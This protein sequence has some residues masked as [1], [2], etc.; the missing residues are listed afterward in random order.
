MLV[1]KYH[2]KNL[3]QALA[4]VKQDLGDHATVL[5]TRTMRRG[6]LG[7]RRVEVTAALSPT[8]GSL[9]TLPSRDESRAGEPSRPGAASYSTPSRPPAAKRP[10][11]PDTAGLAGRELERLV[12]PLREEIRALRREVS[13]DA[14]T[15]RS[16][17]QLRTQVG[18]LQEQMR[19][20][21]DMVRIM[22]KQEQERE[23]VSVTNLAQPDD[24]TAMAWQ[25]DSA[26]ESLVH[27]LAESGMSSAG[28]QHVIGDVRRVLPAAPEEGRAC[29]T[30]LAAQAIESRIQCAAGILAKGRPVALVGPPGV[31][32]TTTLAKI[33]TRAALIEGLNVGVIG[34]DTDTL[35]ASDALELLAQTVGVPCRTART[36]EQL[37]EACA[38]L[39]TCDLVMIDTG[40]CSPRDATHMSELSEMLRA[41]NA[42]CHLVLNADVRA[43]ELESSLRAFE[44]FEPRSLCFTRLDHAVGAGAIF[45]AAMLSGLPVSLLCAGRRIPDDLEAANAPRIASLIMGFQFN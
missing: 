36:P 7:P 21:I 18:N 15:A 1:R 23:P 33:V 22:H 43:V 37:R 25:P 34:C 35:G 5:T 41:V 12:E 26:L 19:D 17:H 3:R 27:K 30:A 39:S 2:G 10:A 20:L 24:V 8:I 44:L 4:H 11:P 9:A 28:I 38:Q 14:N 16:E 13:S 6:L 45:D 29:G 31:G 32:K 42:S 40:G